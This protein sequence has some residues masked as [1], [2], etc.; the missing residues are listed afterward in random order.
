MFSQNLSLQKL[1]RAPEYFLLFSLNQIVLNYCS[2]QLC[3]I[4]VHISISL[5]LLPSQTVIDKTTISNLDSSYLMLL[6]YCFSPLFVSCSLSEH[7]DLVSLLK[8]GLLAAKKLFL[9]RSLWTIEG[10]KLHLHD[11][12][13]C[14]VLFF[15][16]SLK[17][18][19][20]LR[21]FSSH[22]QDSLASSFLCPWPRLINKIS[23]YQLVYHISRTQFAC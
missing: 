6:P 17:K 10:P 14:W 3:F 21:S 20:T 23:L 22:F 15:C 9:I 8:S 12:A 13:R 19:E 2:S 5:Q 4:E 11:A 1:F 16:S 7:L 18:K